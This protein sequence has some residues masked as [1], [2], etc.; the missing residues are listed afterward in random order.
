MKPRRFHYASDI[1]VLRMEN[2]LLSL[3]VRYLKSRLRMLSS[4]KA[5]RDLPSS[6]LEGDMRFL[7]SR[8][9]KP[10]LGWILRTRRGFRI[11]V[12]RYLR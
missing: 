3:E 5:G 11:L 1:D 2:E 8:L 7:L 9:S 4:G 12:E 6:Q 10:P